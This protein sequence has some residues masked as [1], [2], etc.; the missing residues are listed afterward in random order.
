MA[1]NNKD[2]LVSEFC[3]ITGASPE[4]ATQYLEANDWQV[5]A[6]S[7]SFYQDEDEDTQVGSSNAAGANYT[8]PRTLDGRPAPSSASRPAPSTTSQ[9]KRKGVATLG[10][11][12]SSKQESSHRDD[13]DDDDHTDDD[14]DESRGNLFAGGEKSALA[15]QDPSQENGPRKIISDILA[16]AKENA[17]QPDSEDESTNAASSHQFRGTGMTLGGDGVESRT[18]PDPSGVA[19]PRGEVLERVLHIWQD[20]F[21]IDDGELRRYDDPANQQD[22]S[23]IRS[24]RAPLHLMNVQHDQAVD[25]KLEQHDT[26]YKALPKKWKAFSGSGQRLGSPVPG[27]PVATPAP[28]VSR[29]AAASSTA[30]PSS[31]I[32]DI[33]AS[34]P[35]VTIRLQLPDGTRLPARFNTTSTLG[36]VYSFI[37]RASAETQ[38][39]PWVLVTTFPNKEHTDKSLVL[40]EMPEF[41]KGGTAVVKWK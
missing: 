2:S 3:S 27:G 40:G 24:G 10:S 6:A 7:N 4:K 8:G 23:M 25:V 19:R 21:S 38:A 13:D 5:S 32:P 29:S 31:P 22:L 30:A 16:K 1:D 20:G 39:R 12:H 28:A 37:G 34:Q 17:G 18:I 9:P 33:D 14:D 41:K 26:P 15:V 35:T 11:L 36:D